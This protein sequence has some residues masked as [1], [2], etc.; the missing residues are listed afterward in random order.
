M[1]HH[2]RL[3]L[4]SVAADPQC[5][6]FSLETPHKAILEPLSSSHEEAL[7]A[8]FGDLSHQT[9]R[10][11]SVTD[12]G[13]LAHEHCAA[14]ARYDKLRLVLRNAD[15]GAIVALVEFSFDLTDGDLERFATYGLGLRP[16]TD[17]RWGL[18]VADEW[19]GRGVGTAMA[20]PSFEIAR[21]FGRE[22][23]ILWGGVQAAN[24]TAVI[25]YRTVGFTATGR[26]TN[27]DGI[28]CV[29]MLRQLGEPRAA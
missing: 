12:G 10:F 19:Q 16:E 14:I 6:T 2:G 26:F 27:D 11:Y 9:R 8:F 24:S 20:P 29:D 17:C 25:Y 3:T 13:R 1:K 15:E 21:R 23:V 22:R 18:C 5:A 4:K 28:E 7:A